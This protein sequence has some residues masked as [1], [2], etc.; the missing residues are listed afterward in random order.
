[1]KLLVGSMQVVVGQTKTHHHAGGFKHILEIGDDRNRTA[2]ADKYSLLLKHIMQGFGSGFDVLVVGP[3]Y[4]SGTFAPDFDRGL[5]PLGGEFLH[6]VFVT[7]Q[8]VIRVL[9]G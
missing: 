8:D 2:R 3:D 5:N 9:V 7:L 1:M 6:V 4:A